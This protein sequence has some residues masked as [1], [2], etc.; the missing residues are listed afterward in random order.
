[1]NTVHEVR[2]RGLVAAVFER[3]HCDQQPD[4]LISDIGML[5]SGTYLPPQ[6]TAGLRGHCRT[7]SGSSRS[8]S[9]SQQSSSTEQ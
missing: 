9:S 3:Q 7:D 8:L 1:M 6:R 5:V 4:I 2:I